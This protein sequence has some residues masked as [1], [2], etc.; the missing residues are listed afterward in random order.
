MTRITQCEAE[1]AFEEWGANCG[2]GAL[3]AI[4]GLTLAA[5]RPHL[6]NFEQKRY[7][8]P[9]LMYAALDSLGVRYE[10]LQD[11]SWPSWGLV[12][13]QWEG[14][15]QHWIEKA[16]HTHWIGAHTS[17]AVGRAVFD[18]NCVNNGTGWVGFADWEQLIVPWLTAAY[19]EATGGW[20]I[21]NSVEVRD[22]RPC[23]GVEH[24]G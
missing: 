22:R 2:P 16:R 14:P 20:H 1:H 18:I 23:S 17:K 15:W 10:K 3:A 12:R 6:G 8:N 9:T 4:V 21:A 19:P 7:T 13:V 24:D 5:V 11:K